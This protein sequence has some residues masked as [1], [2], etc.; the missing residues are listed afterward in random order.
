V[1]PEFEEFLGNGAG[2]LLDEFVAEAAA[3]RCASIS[4]GELLA[5]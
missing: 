4:S 5:L 1:E 3:Y 2:T